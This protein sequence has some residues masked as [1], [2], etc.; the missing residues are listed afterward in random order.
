MENKD[1]YL[2]IKK[3]DDL[4]SL[5]E[6][7]SNNL[8]QLQ[9]STKKIKWSIAVEASLALFILLANFFVLRTFWES[10]T[11]I[12]A[13]FLSSLL[14]IALC[15]IRFFRKYSKLQE[16]SYD[17]N[18]EKQILYKFRRPDPLQKKK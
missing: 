3:L 18:N 9:E 2:E 11:S 4:I 12:I 1:K 6:D 17:M 7:V 8:A 14:F 13:I 10:S 15:I 5:A 16:I